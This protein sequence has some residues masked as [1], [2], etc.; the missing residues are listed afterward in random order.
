MRTYVFAV[1]MVAGCWRGDGRETTPA[2]S[3]AEGSATV[4]VEAGAP[5]GQV[6]HHVR[7]VMAAS[8]EPPV[9]KRADQYRELIGRRCSED[10]WSMELKR[11]LLGSAKLDD[12][13]G[14]E[15]LATPEQQK[16]LE[17]DVELMLNAN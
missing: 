11:C 10:G 1:V 7:N 15:Q 9:A 3:E 4:R 2:N 5:C 17:A 6:A 12:T 14:C 16:K 13:N 8:D